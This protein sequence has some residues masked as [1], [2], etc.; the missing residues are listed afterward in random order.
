[1]YP[2]PTVV[3]ARRL[4]PVLTVLVMAGSGVLARKLGQLSRTEDYPRN[5]R[6]LREQIDSGEVSLRPESAIA[7]EYG[8][9]TLTYRAGQTIKTGGGVRVQFPEAFHAGIRNSAFRLQAT[10]QTE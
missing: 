10:Q 7:G 2:R 3:R 1:M 5:P 8:T 4:L 9:W 6:L